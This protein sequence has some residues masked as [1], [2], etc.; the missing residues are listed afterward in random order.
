VERDGIVSFAGES[1]KIGEFLPLGAGG[2]DQREVTLPHLLAA[3]EKLHRT[4][5]VALR[6]IQPRQ[7]VEH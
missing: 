3:C 6:L 5:E 7:V 2:E 1:I 4:C